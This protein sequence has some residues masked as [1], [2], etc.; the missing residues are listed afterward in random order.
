MPI[1]QGAVY[2]R[3]RIGALIALFVMIGV[4]VL[5][6][7]AIGRGGN[8]P[9]SSSTGAEAGS[10]TAGPSPVP[11][12]ALPSPPPPFPGY[13]LIA[14]RGNDR[15]LLV[16]GAKH[17]L[18]RYPHGTPS[19]P[20]HFDDDAFFDHGYSQIITNQED[21]QTI[22][23]LSFPEGNVLWHYG[24]LNVVGSAPGYLN[25]PDDAYLL[26]N[27][28][29]TVADAYNCRV[30]FISPAKKI[31]RQ[32]GTTGVC[33]HDPPRLLGA[34][35]GDTPYSG[36]R[37]LVTEITG[38]WVDA[39]GPHNK[40]LWSIQAP[41]GYPSDAQWLGHGRIL[42]AD[43]SSPGHILIMTKT[44]HVLWRY[45]PDTGAGVL[46]HPSLALRL[47]N[48]LIAVNDDFNDRVVVI[49]PS[50]DRIVWQYGI[51]NHPGTAA[52]LLHTPDGMD[53]L[54]YSVARQHPSIRAMLVHGLK[55]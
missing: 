26:R 32:I 1:R 25:S 46:D 40:L 10:G 52:G 29:R 51:K 14:D 24:H 37:M 41:V 12:R 6:V 5:A 54:P 39:I 55:G 36:G 9:D 20:F 44:G 34:P 21:Q 42:L 53:F 22:E 28:I 15:L 48:G 4:I 47:P 30:L 35:N 13:L 3:R 31:V 27:S 23:I 8:S 11:A 17:I 16:D 2:R 38:S 49:D 45:G 19:Y 18:W 7:R 43:Y 50:K 33:G